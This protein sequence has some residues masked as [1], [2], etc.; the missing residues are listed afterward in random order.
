MINNSIKPPPTRLLL[1]LDVVE[2]CKDLER[3]GMDK[4][5]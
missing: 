1:L 3:R 4:E 2:R 5:N